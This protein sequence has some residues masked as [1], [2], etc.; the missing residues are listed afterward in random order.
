VTDGF[1]LYVVVERSVFESDAQWLNALSELAALDVPGLALQVRAKD[2]PPERALSLA[3]EA[4]VVSLD[5]PAPVLLNGTTAEALDLGYQ[6]VHWPEASI[7][8]THDASLLT[9]AASVHSVE[10]AVRAEAAGAE[11]LVAGTIFDA[12]SKPVAGE[13]IEKLRQI[14]TSTALPVLAIGGI[15]PDRVA[16]CIEAGAAGVAVVTSVLRAPDMAAAIRQLRA[17]LDEA[18]QVG[19]ATGS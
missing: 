11:L 13:G 4:R 3:S 8:E 16:A 9:R 15:R 19:S 12:G 14:A 7:P 6:G 17:A 10:A 1:H 2:E 18:E 5:A